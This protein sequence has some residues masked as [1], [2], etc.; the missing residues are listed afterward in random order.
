MQSDHSKR[1]IKLMRPF[2]APCSANTLRRCWQLY[3]RNMWSYC[4]TRDK[5]LLV[6]EHLAYWWHTK[7]STHPC[8]C[9]HCMRVIWCSLDTNR[10]AWPAATHA[11]QNQTYCLRF[12][13]SVSRCGVLW[14]FPSKNAQNGNH[15][16]GRFSFFTSI[17]VPC[18]LFCRCVR[19]RFQD[20]ATMRPKIVHTFNMCVQHICFN[21]TMRPNLNAPLKLRPKHFISCNDAPMYFILC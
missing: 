18:F 4:R 7:Q 6:I 15:M 9:I 3:T 19:P 11:H 13:W 21:V 20:P 17:C 1:P 8:I 12:P 14:K 10:H 2:V 5:H 16:C